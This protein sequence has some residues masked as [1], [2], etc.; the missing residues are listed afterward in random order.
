VLQISIIAWLCSLWVISSTTNIGECVGHACMSVASM[1]LT[2]SFHILVALHH[3][4][5]GSS[6]VIIKNLTS[7]LWNSSS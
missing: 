3:M 4:D 5:H 2:L 6:K 7:I 1:V